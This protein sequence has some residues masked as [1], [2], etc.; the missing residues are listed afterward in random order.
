MNKVVQDSS[1][2]I[3]NNEETR[4]A[5][6]RKRR[7]ALADIFNGIDAKAVERLFELSGIAESVPEEEML[8]MR[9]EIIS[10][11]E[12]FRICVSSQR[13]RRNGMGDIF[14]DVCDAEKTLLLRS[15]DG[16]DK[17]EFNLNTPD[18]FDSCED[19]E[20]MYDVK[21]D[22]RRSSLPVPM[23][24]RPMLCSNAIFILNS[25]LIKPNGK[26]VC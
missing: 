20:G 23:I 3:C 22:Q 19:S 26:D 8:K 11:E 7:N 18:F 12:R 4:K 6:L 13:G 24:C 14:R 21:Q 25:M 9:W 16:Q 1:V 2:D 5:T 17:I 15:K 10:S